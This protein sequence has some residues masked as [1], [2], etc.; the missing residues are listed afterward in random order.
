MT[1]SARRGCGFR[2]GKAGICRCLLERKEF[3]MINWR[4]IRFFAERQQKEA[5]M[6]KKQHSKTLRMAQTAI[7]IALTLIFSLP[8]LGTVRLGPIEMTLAPIPVAIGAIVLGPG[9]GALLGGV[10]GVGSFLQ[11]IIGSS[12][13][14][15][16][17]LSLNWFTTLVVCMLPRILC[18]WLSG[19]LYRAL[20]KIDRTR[21]ASYFAASLSTALLN[22]LFFV[23]GILA[24]FWHSDAFTFQMNEWG[25]STDTL[26]LFL[27]A[28]VGINGVVEAIVNFIVAGGAA[29]AV[30]KFVN[31]SN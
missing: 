5:F 9:A 24:F 21:I 14:G 18:G 25:M 22:T 20:Q 15:A 31:K 12:V 4:C 30:A 13:F 11:C 29:K 3:F 17:L 8:P 1:D 16:F 26:W 28:L 2:A 10:F 23:L 19:L 7:L 27:V 6:Q